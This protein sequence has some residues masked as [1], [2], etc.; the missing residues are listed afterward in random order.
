M[1]FGPDFSGGVLGIFFNL[2]E[3][4]QWTCGW[5]HSQLTGVTQSKMATPGME[6]TCTF[7]RSGSMIQF[8]T[9]DLDGKVSQANV[10]KPICKK[11]DRNSYG[12]VSFD[13]HRGRVSSHDQLQ[14]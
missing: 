11:L 14:L 13:L 7:L 2:N 5:F 10:S 1:Y 3:Q 4:T 12:V 6:A 8:L 9:S